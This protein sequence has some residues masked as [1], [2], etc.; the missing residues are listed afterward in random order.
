MNRNSGVRVEGNLP[1]CLDQICPPPTLQ[2]G[3]SCRCIVTTSAYTKNENFETADAIYDCIGD[4]GEERFSLN[5]LTP[6]GVT[7]PKVVGA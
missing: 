7:D 3:R 4:A 2:L 5:D 6:Q 1:T